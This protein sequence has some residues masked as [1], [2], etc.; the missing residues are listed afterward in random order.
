MKNRLVS[1]LFLKASDRTLRF[2]A[3]YS[4]LPSS[5]LPILYNMNI[6]RSPSGLYLFMKYTSYLD[7]DDG[8]DIFQGKLEGTTSA[9]HRRRAQCR[10]STY[11]IR[12][13]YIRSTC[14]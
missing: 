10:E 9:R 14:K 12:L 11:I 6:Q 1:H 2:S 5:W 4:E 13:P 3:G 7:I 8:N